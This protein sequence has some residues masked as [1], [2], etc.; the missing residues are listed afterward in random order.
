MTAST[1]RKARHG[2]CRVIKMQRWL[3][4]LVMFLLFYLDCSMKHTHHVVNLSSQLPTALVGSLR[5]CSHFVQADA[6]G[7]AGVALPS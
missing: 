7:S 1:G 6:P 2:Y 4:Y 5:S 3:L